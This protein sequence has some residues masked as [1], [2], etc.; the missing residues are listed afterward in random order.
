MK[1]RA[2]RDKNEARPVFD[3]IR[4]PLAPPGH[5]LG[6]AKPNEKARPSLRKAKHKRRVDDADEQQET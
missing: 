4:K 3:T 1:K 5:P 6:E 2:K